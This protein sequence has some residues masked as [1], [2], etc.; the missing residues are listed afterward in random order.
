MV[1]LQKGCGRRARDTAQDTGRMCGRPV[2]ASI[3]TRIPIG[4]GN[5]APK[6]EPCPTPTGHLK[7]RTGKE[8]K[9]VWICGPNM[10]GTLT[11]ICAVREPASS[12]KS[13]TTSARTAVP[14][15][16]TPVWLYTSWQQSR[17]HDN[18]RS[19]RV[20]SAWRWFCQQWYG[21]DSVMANSHLRRRRDSTQLNSTT[22]PGQ[23]TKRGLCTAAWHRNVNGVIAIALSPTVT[24]VE[25]L[26]CIVAVNWP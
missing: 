9:A 12:A 10:V 8:W 7:N 1:C 22:Q 13:V 26:C 25:L 16:T 23:Q 6:G 3:R 5:W 21:N 14:K 18:A 17:L 11:T 4:I 24:T 15:Y 20:R 19:C 2:N